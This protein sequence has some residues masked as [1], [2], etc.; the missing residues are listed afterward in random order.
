MGD[1]EFGFYGKMKE[2]DIRNSRHAI[3]RASHAA[4]KT[5]M[6]SKTFEGSG[7]RSRCGSDLLQRQV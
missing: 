7:S 3:G 2:A 5:T 1:L 6:E 4:H